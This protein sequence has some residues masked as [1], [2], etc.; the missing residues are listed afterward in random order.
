MIHQPSIN[1]ADDTLILID[2]TNIG[3]YMNLARAYEEEFSVLT[4]KLP[5]EN[6]VFEPDTLPVAPY[7]GYLLYKNNIP[8]GFCVVELKVEINDVAEFYIIPSMRNNKLG[9]EL[10]VTIF[11]IH[12]GKWQVRQIEGAD[13][14]RKFWRKVINFYTDNNYAEAEVND[15]DWGIVT[16]Q[17][18]ASSNLKKSGINSPYSLFTVENDQSTASQDHSAIIENNRP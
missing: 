2:E 8:I 17:Q 6:G 9:Q 5:D 13:K 11:D 16:R 12:P 10:A 18:F 1:Q 7:T 3:V 4:H 14:A 15:P